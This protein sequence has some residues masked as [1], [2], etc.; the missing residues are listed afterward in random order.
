MALDKRPVG[1]VTL[2][3][4]PSTPDNISGFGRGPDYHACRNFLVR[5]LTLRPWTR[6][7]LN[8][9][10]G[11]A[12]PTPN[13]GTFSGAPYWAKDA[14]LLPWIRSAIRDAC[15][16]AQQ[17]RPQIVIDFHVGFAWKNL[18]TYVPD[19]I[20]TL[21]E[22]PD[23]IRSCK[24]W[25]AGGMDGKLCLD[26]S[27]NPSEAEKPVVD[28]IMSSWPYGFLRE[29]VPLTP[30]G[31]YLDTERLKTAGGWCRR[32]YH[33]ARLMQ[34]VAPPAP[35][36]ECVVVWNGNG[37]DKDTQWGPTVPDM[38]DFRKRGWVLGCDS[39]YDDAMLEA[40]K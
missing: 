17:I 30:D 21:A 20:M 7:Q 26:S 1:F 32:E 18:T 15:K 28:A 35:F 38:Q 4:Q 24:A 8:P 29:G 23:F 9:L 16:E 2:G 37:P 10:Y 36:H 19:H 40:M 22:V 39:R 34:L 12:Q 11:G 25:R 14:G 33:P 13:L 27:G 3:G 5:E 31:Q 6:F